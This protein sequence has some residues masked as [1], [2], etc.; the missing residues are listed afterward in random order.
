MAVLKFCVFCGQN[1][2]S[3]TKEH[4]IPRWLITLTGK[5]NRKVNLGMIKG[6]GGD[7]FKQRQYSFG[8]FTFPACN[9]CN[10]EYSD[11]EEQ[12]KPILQKILEDTP[13]I[14]DEL[15]I[16]FD[17]F[18]KVRI[19]LWLGYHQLDKNITN[20]EP[21]FHIATRIGQYDR[22]L[23]ISK[24]DAS[25]NKLNFGGVDNFS[26][27]FTPSAFI[28]IINNY[29]FSNISYH[30]LFSRRIG[31]PYPRTMTVTPEE[32]SDSGL[33]A[34]IVPGNGRI[35]NPL[36]RFPISLKCI[37]IYQPMYKGGLIA[38]KVDEYECDYVRNNSLDHQNG[39][40]AIFRYEN[41]FSQR[42]LSREPVSLVPK[43]IYKDEVLF[44][45]SAIN[46]LEWQN[47]LNSMQPDLS[48]LS[49]KQRKNRL[50]VF[51]QVSRIN[52]Y[53]I[54]EQE[55]ILKDLL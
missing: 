37:E 28:L 19:G 8:A 53:F 25:R 55:K 51:Q 47:F 4:I 20:I 38:T 22:V 27:S 15:T 24:S 21:T 6:I 9:E 30:F 40:G 44:Y 18:D 31:F 39:I 3:K 29:Y 13:V 26:F 1:P 36:I 49:K 50:S 42:Y 16:L 41:G 34:D 23:L 52:R 12:T 35:M 43:Y 48:L 17:W 2:A 45:K 11:L 10:N 32:E 5:P 14:S 54:G 46:I 33:R 7:A